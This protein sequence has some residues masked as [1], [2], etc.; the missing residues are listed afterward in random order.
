MIPAPLPAD[1]A[2]RL[3]EL[4]ALSILDTPAEAR[5]DRIVGLAA[6]V[7]RTPIAYIAMIDSDRQWLKSRCGLETSETT[8]GVSFCAHTILQ[9]GPLVVPD[10]RLDPRFCDS[11]LVVGDPYVRF[12]AGHP[13]A[14]PGGHNVGTLCLADHVPRTLDDAELE[15]LGRLAAMAQ[16]ELGMLNLIRSQR[17]LLDTKSK[18]IEA[19]RRLADELAEAAAYVQSLLPPPLGSPIR[20]DWQFV[21]SSEL[22]GD[23]FSYRWLDD[24]RL[25]IYLLDVMGH[26]VGAAL[27]ST[28]IESALRGTTLA[29]LTFDDPAGVLGAL[30]LAFPMEQND[31]RFFSMWYGVYH[32][33]DRSLVYANA[34]H[35][36]ALLFDGGSVSRLGGTGTMVGV[37]PDS[38]FCARRV[39]VPPGSR[40]Y[41]YSDGAYEVALP[42][43][44]MLLL[45]GLEALIA[46]AQAAD[47]PR[48]AE[49][50]R[51]IREAQGKAE[52]KDD[53]SILEV[54]FE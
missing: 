3:A 46:R 19:Q 33:R 30:N 9:D 11:P 28:S 54:E 7:F 20:T 37:M 27:L 36:P 41:L 48:T 10:A 51:L 2:E 32:T 6:R 25:A 1:E 5:F 38:G 50:V 15:I 49:V 53:V 14:G 47:R 39:V 16:H 22:G 52:F 44:G 18:L 13:L 34:G 17:E 4:Q 21:S 40:L 26:G 29:G 24:D 8:R 23:F 42:G 43:G 35:P 31:G 12:Y 45:E